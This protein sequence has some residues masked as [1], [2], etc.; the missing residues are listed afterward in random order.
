MFQYENNAEVCSASHDSS[1]DLE[2]SQCSLSLQESWLG[3]VGHGK[4]SLDSSSLLG[5]TDP[6]WLAGQGAAGKTSVRPT[7]HPTHARAP[8]PLPI[9][10]CQDAWP[11]QTALQQDVHQAPCAV[12]K[13][14][15]LALPVLAASRNSSNPPHSHTAAKPFHSRA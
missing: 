11:P 1:G 2:N 5:H 14:A 6:G 4:A 10:Y 3:A 13:P 9:P 15:P 7:Q 12:P 8:V